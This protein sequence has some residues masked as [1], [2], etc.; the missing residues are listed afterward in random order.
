MVWIERTH[1]HLGIETLRRS[2]RQRYLDIHPRM[3][4][5]TSDMVGGKRGP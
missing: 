3:V 4:A 1:I 5:L 2:Q